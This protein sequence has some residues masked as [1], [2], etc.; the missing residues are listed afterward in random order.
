MGLKECEPGYCIIVDITVNS[1]MSKAQPNK[2]IV[3]VGLDNEDGHKRLTSSEDFTIM[4][5]SEETHEKITETL[6]K[7]KETLSRKGKDFQS[8]NAKELT[9]TIQ[10][11]A[12]E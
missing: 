6:L 1:G 9:D 12:S 8:A 7:T 3:G 2:H 11:K 5:G 10:E 4:G